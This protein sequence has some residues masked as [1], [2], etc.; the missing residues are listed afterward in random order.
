MAEITNPTVQIGQ[1]NLAVAASRIVAG[2]TSLSLRNNANT[3][4]NIL[5]ADAGAVTVRSTLTVTAGGLTVSA[6]TTAVQ[7][8]TA[9]SGII[10]QGA[11]DGEILTFRS[12]DVAHGMTTWTDTSTYGHCSKVD[13][14]VGGLLIRGY[15]ETEQGLVCQ[16]FVTTDSSVRSTAATGAIHFTAHLKNLTSITDM[17]ADKNLVVFRN[18]GT[19][20]FILDSDGD[21][22]QDVGTAWTNFD[23]HD[24]VAL[25][26]LL[27]A[28]ITKPDDPLRESFRGWLEQNRGELESTRLVTFNDDGHHFVNMS[29]LSMLLV[30]AM[31]QVGARVEALEQRLLPST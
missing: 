27:S 19:T 4:D 29:R 25:L 21:S 11:G 18:N 17:A 14:T 13:G 16:S 8:L 31:R 9:T 3:A 28:H 22:H 12:S 1:L 7:A 5:V 26:N 2:A 24:D 20:R 23:T 15:S 10:D 6:G 30:G